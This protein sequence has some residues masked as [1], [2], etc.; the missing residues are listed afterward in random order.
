MAEEKQI[1]GAENGAE[2]IPQTSPVEESARAQGWVPKEE[3]VGDEHRWVDAA[4]FLRRGEL[5]EKIGHQSKKIKELEEAIGHFKGHTK[6]VEEA[7]YKRALED[8]R[9]QKKEAL[10]EGD[11]DKV[12]EIDEK[13]DEVREARTQIQ[14]EPQQQAQQEHPVFT[15]WKTRNGW[16]DKHAD[17]HSW[18]DARGIQ[19]RNEG[20]DPMTVLN[21]LEKEVREKFSTRFENPNRSKAA[22][23]EGSSGRQGSSPKSKYSPSADEVAIAKR[24]VR[25][26]LYKNEQ[27]YYD[28]L[29]K[30]SS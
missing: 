28:E 14:Q 10:L 15:Y 23:V 3:F 26:G 21:T 25:T 13:I 29:A 7:A 4:E 18:A 9:A 24:F 22:A 17:M 2:N 30:M 16:Y 6:K 27:E 1:E 5:F 20:A 11:A 12:I 19:L 8:L